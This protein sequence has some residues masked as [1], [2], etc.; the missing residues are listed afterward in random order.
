MNLEESLEL[1]IMHEDI[2]ECV[3]SPGKT[4]DHLVSWGTEREFE[5]ILK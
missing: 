4:S 5:M 1:A 3:Q 2:L